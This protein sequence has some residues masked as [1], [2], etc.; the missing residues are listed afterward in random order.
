MIQLQDSILECLHYHTLS[1][2]L[3]NEIF[4]THCAQ[5][6]LCFG[7]R[8]VAKL[9][10]RLIFLMFQLFSLVL[11]TSHCMQLK[12]PHLL[13]VGIPQHVRTHHITLYAT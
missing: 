5:I 7:P 1:N 4:E 13:I 2:M 10:A 11:S 8:V 6:L 9:I 12:L 3:S